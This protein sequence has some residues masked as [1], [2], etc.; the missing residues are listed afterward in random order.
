MA[1]KWMVTCP[2]GFSFSTPHGEDDA[3]AVVQ[4]HVKRVHNQDVSREEAAKS[5]KVENET[6]AS[7]S[8]IPAEK[9]GDVYEARVVQWGGMNVSFE[10][11]LADMNVTPY[12]KGLPNNMDQC[13]HW[14]YV[15]KGK[16]IV[17]YKDHEE[18][19]NAGEAY[20]IAPGHTVVVTKGTELIEFSPVHELDRTMAVVMKNMQQMS[21]QK[22]M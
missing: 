16:L 3:V 11:A 2:C 7:I 18:N 1:K 22:Q 8:Q 13:P 14:G 6:H 15:F 10:K 19:V 4:L 21:T 17:R 20:Y 9:M 5:I 12:L